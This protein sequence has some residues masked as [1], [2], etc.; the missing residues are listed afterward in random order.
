MVGISLPCITKTEIYEAH[1]ALFS[2]DSCL[3]AF[4]IR[5]VTLTRKN[6]GSVVD[7]ITVKSNRISA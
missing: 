2:R 7:G 1:E 4:V 6:A 5:G 3:C